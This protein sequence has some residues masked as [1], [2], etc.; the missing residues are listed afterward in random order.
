M[1]QPI[2]R[3]SS[4]EYIIERIRSNILTLTPTFKSLV[5]IQAFNLQSRDVACYVSTKKYKSDG[6][7]NN[8]VRRSWSHHDRIYKLINELYHNAIMIPQQSMS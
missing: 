5:K 6:N 7:L 4:L 8:V 3:K 1:E 2:N